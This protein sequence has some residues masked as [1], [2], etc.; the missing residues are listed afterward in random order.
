MWVQGISLD[1][2][3]WPPPLGVHL[4]LTHPSYTLTYHWAESLHHLLPCAHLWCHS[5]A[6]VVH[7]SIQGLG[8][9][10]CT[11]SWL[12]LSVPDPYH[13]MYV[14]NWSCHYTGTYYWSPQPKVYTPSCSDYHRYL[15]WSLAAG[16]WGIAGESSSIAATVD[17]PQHLQGPHSCSFYRLQWPE[18]TR[19]HIPPG[20]RTAIH[21]CTWYLVPGAARPGVTK[22]ASMLPSVGEDL[23]LLKSLTS[24]RGDCFFKCAV[25]YARLQG[26]EKSGK[27]NSTKRTQ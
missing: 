2:C 15:L 3:D 17:S 22:H 25:A 13:H 9:C 7:T 1:H 23:S 14:W 21:S 18:P 11:H 16:P 27:L 26:S 12:T 4:G 24:G 5:A 20:C 6:T 8:S 19:L 10:H